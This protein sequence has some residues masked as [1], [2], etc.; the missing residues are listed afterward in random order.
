MK[1]VFLSSL[2]VTT[3]FLLGTLFSWGL[4][5]FL[6]DAVASHVVRPQVNDPLHVAEF[7]AQLPPSAHAGRLVAMGLGM[8]LGTMLVRR[9]PGSRQL[10]AWALTL[11]FAAGA[12]FDVFRVN[13]GPALS[14]CTIALVLPCCWM[15]IRLGSTKG[16]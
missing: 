14:I 8:A 4:G 6:Q 13:H 2:R 7:L 16:R 11:L 3:T 12:I 15:G 5:Q 9:W 1:A 10:D